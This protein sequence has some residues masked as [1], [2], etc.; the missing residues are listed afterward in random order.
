M[1]K[2]KVN[3]IISRV[4]LV[5][6]IRLGIR[7]L[8]NRNEFQI[9]GT[10]N[11]GMLWTTRAIIVFSIP[12]FAATFDSPS[13]SPVFSSVTATPLFSSPFLMA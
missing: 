13:F 5:K 1:Y 12:Y 10:K 9:A 2:P 4:S 3:P 6:P 11:A 7:P 8:L